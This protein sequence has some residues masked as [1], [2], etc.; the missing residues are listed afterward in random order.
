M[1]CK[2]LSVCLC[3][4]LYFNILVFSIVVCINVYLGI[5]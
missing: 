2:R 3:L 4:S 5:V 1:T